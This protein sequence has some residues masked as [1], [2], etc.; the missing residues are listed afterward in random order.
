MPSILDYRELESSIADNK[1][2]IVYMDRFK[3]RN[4]AD[5]YYCFNLGEKYFH[6]EVDREFENRLITIIEEYSYYTYFENKN[7][8]DYYLYRPNVSFSIYLR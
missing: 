4:E 5:A 6:Q 3:D 8:L 2:D 7:E 1:D